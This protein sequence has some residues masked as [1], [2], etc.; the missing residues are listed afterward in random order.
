MMHKYAT[1]NDQ[2]KLRVAVVGASGYSGGELLRL[3]AGAPDVE[4][5]ATTGFGQV[6]RTVGE[7]HPFLAG[8][9]DLPLTSY[10]AEALFGLD[11][12]FLA[13]P[14][15][16]SMRVVPQLRDRVG[17]IIDLGGDLRL[18]SAAE[19][20]R[21]YGR[22]HEAPDLLGQ[23]VYGLPEL[24][25]ARIRGARLIANPGC[26]PTSAI[27]ALLPALEQGLVERG[28]LVINALS[29]I[30]GAGRTAKAE[31][32]FTEL[33]ENVRAYRVED[34]QHRPEIA[35]ALAQAA[36]GPVSLTFVPHLLP[37]TRGIYTTATADLA[38][39][40]TADRV[41]DIYARRYAEEP[42]VRFADRVPE[43]RAVQHTNFCD[44]G[45]FVDEAAGKLVAI[46]AIDNLVKGAAG[47]A[48]QNMN[49]ALGRP[50]RSLLP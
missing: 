28:G 42:C 43:L 2:S 15:G 50:E 25:R 12:V 14:A 45:V 21:F 29:G 5:V 1:M 3:L 48:V 7:A 18:A 47:Q 24:N 44:V 8:R 33:N 10:A 6:G 27:L 31:M 41:R 23:A 38:Q 30:S 39:P 37:V 35:A 11:C 40:V 32:S 46:A 49:L 17:C 34:H 26:Y 20:E 4:I 36:G 16:E 19:Y 9:V 22:I 13:L